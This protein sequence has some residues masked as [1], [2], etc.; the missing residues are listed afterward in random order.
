MNDSLSNFR[1]IHI[2]TQKNA[3]DCPSVCQG[4]LIHTPWNMMYLPHD[5]DTEQHHLHTQLIVC[6]CVCVRMC[7]CCGLQQI[8]SLESLSPHPL[9]FDFYVCVWKR[10]RG[11]ESYGTCCH[12]IIVPVCGLEVNVM[13]PVTPVVM[14]SINLYGNRPLLLKNT[15]FTV[16]FF[17]WP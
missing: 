10:E 2:D 1:H 12:G 5:V 17:Y 14:R 15:D 6:E 7:H 11:R 16:S 9:L 13:E 8:S 3:R 4:L